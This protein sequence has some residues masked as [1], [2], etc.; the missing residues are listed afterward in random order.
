MTKYN[1]E[2]DKKND[3]KDKQHNLRCMK[4]KDKRNLFRLEKE[5]EA[6]IVRN[7][8]NLLEH[9]EEDYYK[10]VRVIN[11]WRTVI[12]NMKVM[13]IGIRHYQLKNILIKLDHYF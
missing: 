3:E 6:K 7:I 5:S 13:V 10:P 4:F 8:R 2:K 9:E 11:F 12:I 1:D